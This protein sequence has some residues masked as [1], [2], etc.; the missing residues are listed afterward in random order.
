[1]DSF[2]MEPNDATMK[3]VHQIYGCNNIVKDKTCSKNPI[4]PACIDLIITN[5]KKSFPE[6]QVIETALFVF[7]K[8]SLMVIT[9]LCNKQ[10]LKII[11]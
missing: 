3:K 11:Q 6:S 8:M 10:P 5:R 4:N 2:T 9:V 7:Y 1:M